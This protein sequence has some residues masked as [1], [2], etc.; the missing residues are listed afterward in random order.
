MEFRK[1]KTSKTELI[2]DLKAMSLEISS[3]CGANQGLQSDS[4]FIDENRN[5]SGKDFSEPVGLVKMKYLTLKL[6]KEIV[7]DISSMLTEMNE[8]LDRMSSCGV[9]T[10]ANDD[11]YFEAPTSLPQNQTFKADESM[12]RSGP[13]SL[14]IRYDFKFSRLCLGDNL[15]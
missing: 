9:K 4:G 10:R 2:A 5:D 6:E 12:R 13:R 11:L 3:I 14:D 1:D 8:I 15:Q 7:S